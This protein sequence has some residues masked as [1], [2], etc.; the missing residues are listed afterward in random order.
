MKK[1]SPVPIAMASLF[2]ESLLALVRLLPGAVLLA[3]L[4]FLPQRIGEYALLALITCTVSVFLNF[5]IFKRS[6]S[7]PKW[8]LPAAIFLFLTLETC[9]LFGVLTSAAEQ[10]GSFG[11]ATLG[12]F[13]DL[14]L[15]IAI[16]T[17]G[18][19]Q[20]VVFLEQRAARAEP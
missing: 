4:G 2:S 3:H 19:R 6:V 18:S 14:V 16:A 7:V 10:I 15:R 8:I 11:L 17:L 20:I 9:Q 12:V 1:F 5:W 13:Q